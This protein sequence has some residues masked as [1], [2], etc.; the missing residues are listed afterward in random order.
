MSSY[1]N[2]AEMPGARRCRGFGWHPVE[3]VAM[4]LGFILFWPVGLAILALKIWQRRHN[5]NGDMMDA[6]QSVYEQARSKARG[7]KDEMR[8]GPWSSGPTGQ[9]QTGNSAF[10][11]WRAAELEKLEEARRKVIDAE[12]EF[13]SHI[14][15]LRRARD[16][17][18]FE[19]FMQARNGSP[20][21][22]A[23]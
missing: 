10:N 7:F 12:R 4:V 2:T 5:H 8:R 22:P 21:T 1:A 17:E 15:S 18:E 11:D 9:R 3:L 19:R 16:R 20:S 14:E 13:A 23:S 6:A